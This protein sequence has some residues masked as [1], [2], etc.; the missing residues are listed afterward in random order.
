MSAE[1][2]RTPRGAGTSHAREAPEHN[3]N[4]SHLLQD[5]F[6][7][8]ADG[9]GQSAGSHALNYQ[10]W[11]T[12]CSECKLA[13]GNTGR[14][15]LNRLFYQTATGRGS[16]ACMSFDGFLHAMSTIAEAKYGAT[17]S[18]ARLVYFKIIRFGRTA[19]AASAAANT[20][21]AGRQPPQRRASATPPTASPSPALG[22]GVVD[23]STSD[24]SS[25]SP[26]ARQS[27]P[28]GGGRGERQGPRRGSAEEARRGSG[29]HAADAAHKADA[30]SRRSLAPGHKE[31]MQAAA[32]ENE[33]A[34]IASP[35]TSPQ[36]L[37][38]GERGALL[39]AHAAE[40]AGN[41]ALQVLQRSP[42]KSIRALLKGPM[43][44]K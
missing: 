40:T 33:R 17:D 9:A 11:N 34:N 6:L 27:A 24:D 16:G 18:V 38:A 29:S 10:A 4:T 35:S 42:A 44:R 21:G 26:R 7:A 32:K 39:Q 8:Y 41:D 25:P 12:F 3:A 37:A 23:H 14:D 13:E 2:A 1:Q 43:D 22:R 20:S 36:K 28:P 15:M 30:S 31:I 19:T 5:V